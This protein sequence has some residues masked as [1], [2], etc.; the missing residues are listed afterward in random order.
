MTI[1]PTTKEKRN[2]FYILLHGFLPVTQI[3]ILVIVKFHGV[4]ASK[5]H[6]AAHR[7]T[8]SKSAKIRGKIRKN[9]EKEN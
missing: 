1:T 6:H 5:Y 9:V 7:E 3:Q 2:L 8:P 4:N